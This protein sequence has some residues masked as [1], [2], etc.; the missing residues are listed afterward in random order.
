MASKLFEED[1]FITEE[2]ARIELLS[3]CSFDAPE[4]FDVAVMLKIA[5]LPDAVK[6]AYGGLILVLWTS[7]SMLFGAG[8]L[9]VINKDRLNEAL[10]GNEVFEACSQVLNPAADALSGFFS[11]FQTVS[12]S[13]LNSCANVFYDL[14]FAVFGAAAVVAVAQYVVKIRKHEEI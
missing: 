7:F 10:E 2:F 12:I 6:K 14:R 1:L 3:G 8:A 13:V 11:S 9:L 5:T 4:D